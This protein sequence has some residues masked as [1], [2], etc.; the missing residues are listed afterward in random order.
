MKKTRFN[1][2]LLLLLLTVPFLSHSQIWD[3][4]GI[5]ANGAKVQ[6]LDNSF[7]FTEGP[8]PDKEGNVYFTDQ[9]NNK[10][11]KWIAKTGE[12]KLFTD[13]AGRSNGLFF[14]KNWKLHGCADENNQLWSFDKNGNPTVLVKDF[15][16]KLLNG[17]NDLWI[18]NQGGIYF[19]DPLY[20]RNYWQ[21]DPAMQQDGEFVYYLSP[22]QQLK[23][24]NANIKKP[25]GII[26]TGD[27]KKIY[28]ADIGASRIYSYDVLKNGELTNQQPVIEMGADGM[29]VDNQGNIYLA[30]KGVTVFNKSG[31]K[32]AHIPIDKGWTANVCFGGKKR[33]TLFITAGEAVFSLKMNVKG[34]K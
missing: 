4:L 28:V 26:G 33:D 21:R 1:L 19:T 24:V 31:K 14:D 27:G 23:R 16:G 25:N 30:G 7:K 8:V 12:I 29:T 22:D 17:P 5:V 9:P 32:I 6:L 20:P 3:S 11:F 13:K 15:G 10:I 18:D 2:L 34:V